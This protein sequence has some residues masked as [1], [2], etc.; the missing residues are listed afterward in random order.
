MV[1][2]HLQELVEEQ[3]HTVL[4]TLP[5]GAKLSIALDCWTSPFHQAFMAVTG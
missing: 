3:Q 5:S 4:Q 1:R 2:R